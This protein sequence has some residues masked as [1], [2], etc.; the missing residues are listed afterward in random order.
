MKR[1]VKTTIWSI[2]VIIV[3][4]CVYNYFFSWCYRVEREDY[5]T[6]KDCPYLKKE[7]EVASYGEYFNNI[8]VDK[9]RKYKAREHW[10]RCWYC[11]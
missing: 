1:F 6:D 2:V 8:R 3:V 11:W 9:V 10:E 5:H 4:T 7:I